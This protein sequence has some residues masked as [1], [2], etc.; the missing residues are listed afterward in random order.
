[1]GRN[2]PL[3]LIARLLEGLSTAIVSTLGMALLNDVVEAE[4][5][6]R[7]IGY[8]SMA[9]STGLLLG[10][11]LGGMLYEYG[12]YFQVFYPAIGFIA[13]EM[14]LRLMV[15]EVKPTIDSPRPTPGAVG[16]GRE[17]STKV[18][19][20]DT[21]PLLD[22]PRMP[23][24]AF[25]VLLV[26]P[27]FLV[28]LVGTFVL[29]SIGSGF[30]G[31]LA[32]Y[33]KDEFNLKATHAAAL[34]LA[35]A[36]PMFLAPVSGALADRYGAKWPVAGGF[37]VAIPSLILLRLVTAGTSKPFLKLLVLLFAVGIAL[38][39]TITPLSA[40]ASKIVTEFEQENPGVFGPHGAYS[41]VFGLMSTAS[42]AGS[43]TGPLYTGFVRIWLGWSSMS[44]SLGV[45]CSL[46][47][48]PVAM[49]CGG[50]P[51]LGESRAAESDVSVRSEVA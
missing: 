5:I 7:A 3:L 44:L 50:K 32:P 42:A 41:Q 33:I 14:V 17:T 46:M 21:V 48:I 23:R 40:E 26:S 2:L 22:K 28:A 12:G 10:P 1:M 15:I 27:R 37:I 30:D 45:V 19:A 29:L 47:L 36:L 35:L 9:L 43:L 38:A 39:L 34:F 20:S 8:T 13:V 4:H 16:T 49:F 18:K 24:N 25:S 11:V 6:G 31:V 51:S